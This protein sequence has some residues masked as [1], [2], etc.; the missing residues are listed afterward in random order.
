LIYKK[1]FSRYRNEE[2][3]MGSE[4]ETLTPVQ[5]FGED[6][7]PED[8]N[9]DIYL[10]TDITTESLLKLRKQINKKIY[11]YKKIL[12]ENNLNP[13]FIKSFNINLHIN[14]NGGYVLD[15]LGFYDFIRSCIVPIHTYVEGTAASAATIISVAG[16]R[17]FMTK[18]STFM[19]HQLS[20]WFAG[21][22][23]EFVDEKLNLDVTMDKIKQVYLESTKMKKDK[24]NRL[25]KRDLFL[26]VEKCIEYGFIDEVVD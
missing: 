12:L 21:K 11:N 8:K 25:L 15:S 14:S 16:H 26:D 20:S 1:D 13:A 7:A 23:D 10:H 24:L 17:R 19:I 6:L 18:H 9:N 5:S 22:H 2:E 4:T 3:I